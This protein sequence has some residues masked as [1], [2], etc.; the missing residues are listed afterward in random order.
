MRRVFSALLVTATLAAPIVGTTNA[1]AGEPRVHASVTLRIFDPYRHD[2]HAWDRHE[3]SAYRTYLAERHRRYV[4]YQ[5]QRL[6]E[7]RA[8]WR[9]RHEREER[10]EHERR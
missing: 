8:Y 9:W 5:H 3:E 1:F 6:V 10:L 4:A 2:Y 7:Q